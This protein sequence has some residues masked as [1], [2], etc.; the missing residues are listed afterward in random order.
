MVTIQKFSRALP[1]TLFILFVL[2]VF[3]ALFDP[4]FAEGTAQNTGG[5][6]QNPLG[7]T[8]I[9]QLLSLL[10]KAFVRLGIPIAILFLVYTGFLF[11]TAQGND[12]KITKA[13]TSLL[14]TIIGIAVLV[15]A[16]VMA[17]I[18]RATVE[19]IRG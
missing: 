4:V 14:Y 8:T 1:L 18:I 11:V 17:N 9:A 12:T 6:L 19:S 16:E 10:L 3:L 15:G 5:G 7:N 2:G 13:K